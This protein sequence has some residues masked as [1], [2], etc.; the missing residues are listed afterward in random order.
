MEHRNSCT[1]PVCII[2]ACLAAV[3]GFYAG[4][5]TKSSIPETETAAAEPAVQETEVTQTPASEPTELQLLNREA[6]SHMS[7]EGK[8]I[9]V[10]GHKSPDS[11][12]VCSAIAYARLLNLLGYNAEPRITMAVN[13]E[14]KYIL[15]QAGCETPEILDSAAGE[16][17]FLV[18]HSEYAQAA[19]DMI[20]AHIVGI[21]DHH[22]AGTVNTGHQ[23]VYEARP[24][25]STATIVWLD[26]MNY[27]FEIDKQTACLLLG[28]VLSDTSNCTISTTTEADRKAV[29]ALAELAGV[30]DT[31]AL[32][33]EIH[34]LAMSYDGMSDME[35]MF[36]DYKEYEASGVKYGIGLINST[37]E[38]TSKELAERMKNIAD[39]AMASKDVD[40]MFACAGIREGDIKVDYIIPMSE[41]SRQLMEEAFPNYDEYDGTSFI[42]RN[43][44]L[45]RK[46][47]LVPGLNDFFAA[48]PHE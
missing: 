34:E 18:D 17:I 1:I 10:I 8:M 38:E 33:K 16:T 2:A 31:D 24:I 44:G 41:A 32:Y 21:M 28:A 47:K 12:T 40:Y 19:D 27:G 3:C 22:G 29:P 26:Y 48:H 25:G 9:Y 6:V 14:T 43:G 42:F 7:D 13:S 20:D 4:K 37:K 11:D 45:G 5:H 35:I 30:D 36:S 15:E 23:I 39:E 46:T